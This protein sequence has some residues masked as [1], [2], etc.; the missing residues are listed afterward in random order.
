MNDRRVHEPFV[1]AALAIALASLA[2]G[3]ALRALSQP[4]LALFEASMVH[5]SL[6]AALGRSGLALSGGF[7]I[8]GVALIVAMLGASFRRARP[9]TAGAPILP[10]RPYLATAFAGL[11]IAVLF[12]AALSIFVALSGGYLF[13]FNLNNVIVQLMIYGFV[14]P[15]AITFSIRNLPLFM[16]LAFP[17]DRGLPLLLASYATGLALRL[18][19]ELEQAFQ[20]H[21]RLA[22]QMMGAGGRSC[23]ETSPRSFASR[24]SSLPMSS[25]RTSRSRVPAR[26][27]GSRSRASRR[28]CGE[29]IGCKFAAPQQERGAS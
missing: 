7:E 26:W 12:N 27:A 21:L 2:I 25:A 16:R 3:I 1:F 14:L 20:L 6:F 5:D 11:G 19:A 13:P 22:P 28:I 18:A 24:R 17:P 23:W 9:L 10:V 15:I 8:V 4:L 29:R